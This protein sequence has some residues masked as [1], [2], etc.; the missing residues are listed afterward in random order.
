MKLGNIPSCEKG[1]CPP[2]I[3]LE[4]ESLPVLEHGDYTK[5]KLESRPNAAN[6]EHTCELAI[7]H[8]RG[9]SP[10]RWLRFRKDLDGVFVGQRLDAAADKYAMTRRLLE[11]DPLAK[12]NELAREAGAES[13][14]NFQAVLR[15][16]A[17]H[18]MPQKALSLQKRYMRRF[19]RKP[20]DMKIRE[21][22]ARLQ[23]I[24]DYLPKFPPFGENQKLPQDEIRD[25]VE[26]SIPDSWRNH[27]TSQGFDIMNHT[28]MEFVEFCERLELLEESP[29]GGS[30]SENPSS[31]EQTTGKR[32]KKRGRDNTNH[33]PKTQAH[34]N[35]GKPK[36]NA[37]CMLH[38]PGHS[39]ED[40]R[41]VAAQI[42][43]MKAT[44]E[45]QS[46]EGKRAHKKTQE[47]H[48]IVEAVSD[49]MKSS[50]KRKKGESNAL[51]A[52]SESEDSDTP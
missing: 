8:F 15:G 45:T 9:G 32:G 52:P 7:P 43:R 35:Q 47:T 42:K 51:T 30:K 36:E 20:A 33:K 16:L 46:P 27:A 23:E 2:P 37:I 24:N 25:I 14:H 28:L 5:L 41:V 49:K 22:T 26:F 38:G 11:G 13:P 29:N 18:V 39:T 31:E 21:F 48:A 44:C 1:N 50:K 4:R 12:F 34:K 10:E 40:C 17:Q 19:L 3:P 6:D